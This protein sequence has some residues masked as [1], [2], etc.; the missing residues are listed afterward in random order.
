MQVHLQTA[1]G[2]LVIYAVTPLRTNR[3]QR[4]LTLVIKWV[5]VCPTWQDAVLPDALEYQVVVLV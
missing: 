2:I 5:P 3:T 4:C 1:P